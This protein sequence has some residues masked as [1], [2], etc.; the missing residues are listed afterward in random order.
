MFISKLLYE[1]FEIANNNNSIS[2]SLLCDVIPTKLKI[3]FSFKFK[4]VDFQH[5][6]NLKESQ[7]GNIPILISSIPDN[8]PCAFYGHRGFCVSLDFGS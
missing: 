5:Y 4:T 2:S 7:I 3:D 8:F 1:L 6:N